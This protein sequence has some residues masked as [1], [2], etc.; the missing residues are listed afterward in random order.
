MREAL[1]VFLVATVPGVAAE[2]SLPAGP[3]R[4]LVELVCSKC[5]TTDRI[6]SKAMTKAEWKEEVTEM[7]QEEPDV[8]EEEKDQII[9]YLAKSFPKAEEK[10]VQAS[11]SEPAC[12][13]QS[14]HPKAAHK[15]LVLAVLKG[16]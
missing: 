10:K 14:G 3:N 5:H 7:L 15:P 12:R 2:S 16:K 11:N 6:A 9:E 1:L 4:D 13:T 8:T